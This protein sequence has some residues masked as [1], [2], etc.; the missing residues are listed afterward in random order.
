MIKIERIADFSG[1]Q[2]PVYTVENS[3]KQH[4]IFTGGND[5]GVVEW[6]LKT[7]A[8]VKVL[9]PVKSSIYAMHSPEF[10]PILA[11]GERSGAVQIF[12]FVPVLREGCTDCPG[13]TTLGINWSSIEGNL[14]S[15]VADLTQV[16]NKACIT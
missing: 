16:L 9:M 4:I 2:N 14:N 1:H 6:S 15:F 11:V 13:E 10:S 7:N 8:F 12:N 3:Q 5:K